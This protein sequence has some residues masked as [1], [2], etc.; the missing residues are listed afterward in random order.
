[1]GS[2]E[3][4]PE[5]LERK[6]MAPDAVP[7]RP[8]CSTSAGMD[9]YGLLPDGHLRRAA[10]QL[11]G[12]LFNF[13]ELR[14]Q[15]KSLVFGGVTRNAILLIGQSWFFHSLHAS[16]TPFNSYYIESVSVAI[17]LVGL[18]YSNLHGP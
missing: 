12:D 14:K 11:R 3:V 4:S 7:S 8:P 13:V 10:A 6:W 1:M 17:K 15:T 18:E 16:R 5:R 2:L 9:I